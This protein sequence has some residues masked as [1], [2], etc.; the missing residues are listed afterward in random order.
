MEVSRLCQSPRPGRPRAPI[1]PEQTTDFTPSDQI[2]IALDGAGVSGFRSA[3][4]GVRTDRWGRKW[5]R[6]PGSVPARSLPG[7]GPVRVSVTDGCRSE[8]ISDVPRTSHY[9]SGV[10]PAPALGTPVP[11]PPDPRLLIC[12]RWLTGDCR[13]STG[14]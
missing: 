8:V 14:R 3:L 12:V 13:T 11:R 4:S 5:S 1:A 9:S 7:P 2:K 6:G 10:P